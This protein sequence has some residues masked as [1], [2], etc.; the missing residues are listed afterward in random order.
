MAAR[1]GAVGYTNLTISGG[2]NTGNQTNRSHPVLFGGNSITGS[3]VIKSSNI[4][5]TRTIGVSPILD[6]RSNGSPAPM[7][8]NIIDT[9]AQ[10]LPG[11][12]G[13]VLMN[14]VTGAASNFVPVFG[15]NKSGM[16]GEVCAPHPGD[17]V[18][19]VGADGA[20]VGVSQ[21]VIVACTEV[22][23]RTN[24]PYNDL[25]RSPYSTNWY[26]FNS[27]DTFRN[28]VY[29]STDHAGSGRKGVACQN[30]GAV[31][32]VGFARNLNL[33]GSQG[34][35]GLNPATY[36]GLRAGTDSLFNQFT[37]A[38]VSAQFVDDKTSMGTGSGTGGGN[39]RPATGATAIG[40][41]TRQPRRFDLSGATRRIDGTGAIGAY[42]RP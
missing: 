30:Y 40:M 28:V 26:Q 31:Y 12:S 7:A 29:D 1:A 20:L 39:Y 17:K 13:G 41:A 9:V 35:I 23:D 6:P 19:Q 4:V 37:S 10:G 5:G 2:F 8:I 21:C 15:V 27:I 14:L 3:Q 32:R 34:G 33:L 25:G 16:L 38:T 42:E 18:A 24:G 22:G 36:S 11:T